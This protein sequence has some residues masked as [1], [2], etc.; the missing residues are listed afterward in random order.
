MPVYIPSK[1]QNPK[2]E[3]AY[4]PPPSYE[5]P[6]SS[7]YDN[8]QDSV[9][10]TALAFDEDTG[11]GLLLAKP[12]KNG[13]IITPIEGKYLLYQRS[14]NIVEVN[15]VEGIKGELQ[16]KNDAQKY[17]WETIERTWWD[18]KKRYSTVYL[19][20]SKY[21]CEFGEMRKLG[22]KSIRVIKLLQEKTM[23]ENSKS[24]LNKGS[25]YFHQH[26]YPN[27]PNGDPNRLKGCIGVI[28]DKSIMNE[29]FEKL[30]G[31]KGWE[32]KKTFYLTIEGV[33]F[34]KQ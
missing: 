28:G 11:G 15:N 3:P 33:R 29:I 30:N 31:E 5:N 27:L 9:V 16:V 34:D 2:Q 1:K 20:P 26:K 32:H 7:Y 14:E 6:I 4:Q 22:W 23:G 24:S 17:T 19:P 18:K 12:S 21:L 10:N 8:A 25:I 13:K